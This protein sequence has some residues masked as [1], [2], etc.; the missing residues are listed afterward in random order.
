MFTKHVVRE[1]VQALK[2]QGYSGPM[3]AEPDGTVK[4]LGKPGNPT[5]ANQHTGEAERKVDDCQDSSD[6]PSGN[7]GNATT[8]IDARLARDAQES[9]RAADVKARRQSGELSAHAAAVE[10]GGFGKL[11]VAPGAPRPAG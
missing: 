11:V 2:G 10:M 5:G 1:G 9:E 4:P 6:P 7:G 3:G 8:Y